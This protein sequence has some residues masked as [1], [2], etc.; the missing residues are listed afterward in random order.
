MTNPYMDRRKKCNNGH[1][2]FAEKK[3][4][5]RLGGRLTPASGAK[6]HSKGDFSTDQLLFENKST[7]HKSFSVKLPWLDKITLEATEK[8]KIPALA[9]QFVG[10]TGE[11]LDNG[12]WV[13]LREVDFMELIEKGDME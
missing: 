2:R 11:P 1:G 13:M 4:A 9:M 6:I 8:G 3:A 7:K 12:A 10:T 5:H